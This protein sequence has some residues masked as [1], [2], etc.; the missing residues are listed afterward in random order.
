M[1]K[2]LEWHIAEKRKAKILSSSFPTG[3]GESFQRWIND[4]FYVEY[5]K[6]PNGGVETT[7]FTITPYLYGNPRLKHGNLIKKYADNNLLFDYCRDFKHA[8]T[9]AWSEYKNFSS[10]IYY[11]MKKTFNVIR[12]WDALLDA[13]ENQLILENGIP[14][15]TNSYYSQ[16]IDSEFKDLTPKQAEQILNILRECYNSTQYVTY[17]DKYEEYLVHEF[18]KY[19]NKEILTAAQPRIDVD[20]F[21]CRLKK[22]QHAI[23]VEE[24][25]AKLKIIPKIE[26]AYNDMQLKKN[27]NKPMRQL[28]EDE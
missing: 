28:D 12:I 26:K 8:R 5:Q 23:Q 20:T 17:I 19:C 11:T 1:F 16:W 25:T 24:Y 18:A 10:D 6:K 13:H 27:A 3:E 2:W 4:Y 22:I 21:S 14:I 7:Y 15:H 9:F